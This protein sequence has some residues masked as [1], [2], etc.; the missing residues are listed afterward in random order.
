MINIMGAIML[1]GAAAA[2]GIGSVLRLKG[3]V[4]NLSA[5]VTALG[6]MRGEI[7]E[8]LTPMPE[9]LEMLRDESP[10]SLIHIL[11]GKRDRKIMCS[12]KMIHSA[13]FRRFQRGRTHIIAR[14]RRGE[15]LFKFNFLCLFPA[16]RILQIQIDAADIGFPAGGKRYGRVIGGAGRGLLIISAGKKFSRGQI[17]AVWIYHWHNIE[18]RFGIKRGGGS[19]RKKMCIRDRYSSARWR[20]WHY[21]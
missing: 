9:L 8:R 15:A 14:G 18:R 4:Q 5:L 10:L 17:Y 11:A 3:R 1:A 2:W 7:C 19:I 6:V 20:H 12:G 21:E 13:A 16:G